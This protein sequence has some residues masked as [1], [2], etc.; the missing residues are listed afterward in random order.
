VTKKNPN[1]FPY[2]NTSH[3]HVMVLN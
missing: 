3:Q 2:F 1:I